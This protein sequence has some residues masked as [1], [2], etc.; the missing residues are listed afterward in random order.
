M[1]LLPP[2]PTFGQVGDDGKRTLIKE[3][4]DGIPFVMS[5]DVRLADLPGVASTEGIISFFAFMSRTRTSTN[6]TLRKPLHYIIQ[7]RK[8]V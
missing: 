3:S 5:R 7:V 4:I 1:F 8:C 6:D 2:T